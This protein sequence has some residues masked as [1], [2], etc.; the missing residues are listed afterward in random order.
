[1]ERFRL[2]ACAAHWDG[3]RVWQVEPKVPH[4]SCY[5]TLSVAWNIPVTGLRIVHEKASKARGR[6]KKDCLVN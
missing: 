4:W 5:Q 6:W 1:M 2:R 3:N